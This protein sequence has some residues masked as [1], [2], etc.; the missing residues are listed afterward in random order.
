MNECLPDLQKSVDNLKKNNENI[1]QQ[2][3]QIQA[4]LAETKL[5]TI[6]TQQHIQV[7]SDSL[8]SEDQAQMVKEWV[9]VGSTIFIQLQIYV[10]IVV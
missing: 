5:E 1:D 4:Q 10:H 9:L 2:I 7:M 8:V 3:I 6:S